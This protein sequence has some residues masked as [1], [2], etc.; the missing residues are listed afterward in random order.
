ML[1]NLI[2]SVYRL[3]WGDLFTIPL[4]GGIGI[5]FMVVLLFTAGIWFTCRTRLLPVRLFRDM[6]AA[7]CE[8]K[9]GRD[10]LSS[11][12]TL[13]ISTATRVGMGN[14]VGVVAAVSAGGAGAV[15]LMWVTAI[16]GASTSFIESTLAQKYRQPDPLYG[17]WRG[18]PAYYLHVLAERR[19]GKKLKRSVAAALFAVSGLICWCGISQVISNSVSSAF[20]NAFHIPPLTTTLV[21][22]AIAAVIV[23]RKNATVKSLDVMVP[24]MAVCYFVITVGVVLFNLPK[25]PAVFGRIFAEAFGLR[26]AVAGGFGAVL[27]NGVKRGLFSNEAGSGSAPCAAAAAE[28]DDPVKMGFV[29][30]LGVLIDTVV[31][32]SCTAFLMLLVPQEITEG[33]AGMD[34]LQTALQYHLGGFGVVFIAATLA[35]FSFSTFLGV[36]YYARGNVAYLCGDNWWSQTVYKLIALVMLVIGGMQ[37]YTVVWD[38]GDVGIGLMTIFNMIALVPMAKEALAALNDYEKRK[39]LQ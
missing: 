29:Q 30:A 22:T 4:G 1:V 34:L 21:L 11:F 27:M 20:E 39:K 8:K 35:L 14:L 33:L 32:C 12:Q 25:L 23:L 13:V 26:Q 6:I 7:V 19:R 3:L 9:Q 36:L 17:G 24:I 18:G 28:C 37:A 15:F 2:E 31:I 16:L 10:G 38:L 5:S